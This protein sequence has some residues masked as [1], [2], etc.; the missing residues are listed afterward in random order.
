MKP[1]AKRK[2]GAGRLTVIAGDDPYLVQEEGRALFE[3]WRTEW[4]D[5]EAE[6]VDGDKANAEEAAEA[7]R[8][9]IRS[10][11]GLSLFA[12]RKILWI[13]GCSF[14]GNSRAAQAKA[15]AS[16]LDALLEQFE[17]GLPPSQRA[18]LT[19]VQ[20]DKRRA[21]WKRLAKTAKTVEVK[22][23]GPNTRNWEAE[24]VQHVRRRLGARGLKMTEEAL[25]EFIG[26]VGPNPGLLDAELEKTAVYA[27]EKTIRKEHVEAIATRGRYAEAFALAEAVGNRDTAAALKALDEELWLAAFSREKSPIGLLYGLINK[28]RTML[29]MKDLAVS[30]RLSPQSGRGALEAALARVDP[31]EYPEDR[32]FNPALMHP[33]AARKALEQSARYT[34]RELIEAMERLLEANLRLV[35]SRTAPEAILRQAVIEIV[36]RAQSPR[37]AASAPPSRGLA[38]R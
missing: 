8:R 15:T 13:K 17:A 14:F 5:A 3:A 19:V 27:G 29:L 31:D 11:A 4:P 2:G 32:R 22:G 35:S 18:L 38:R 9:A 34:R 24:A 12:A 10:L 37:R 36:S 7:V 28:V 30:L 1:E 20:P 23:F 26:L 25:I 21:P 33:Y 16:A 6:V